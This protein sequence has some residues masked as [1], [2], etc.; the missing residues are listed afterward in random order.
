LFLFAPLAFIHVAHAPI[1]LDFPPIS[2]HLSVVLVHCFAAL[3]AGHKN[4]TASM[5]NPTATALA[6]MMYKNSTI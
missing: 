6:M 3:L 5:S 2:C 1:V 4:L